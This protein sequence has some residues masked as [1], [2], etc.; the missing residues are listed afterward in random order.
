MGMFYDGEVEEP[1]RATR[2]V[3]DN[4]PRI[5]TTRFDP[6]TCSVAYTYADGFADGFTRQDKLITEL[7]IAAQELIDWVPVCSEGSSGYLCRTKLEEVIRR[8][9]R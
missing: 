6:K 5:D 9:S 8:C 2:L 3:K 1:Q 4:G 7:C